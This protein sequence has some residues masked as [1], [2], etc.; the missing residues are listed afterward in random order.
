M[1]IVDLASQDDGAAV[2]LGQITARTG[3]MRD[4]DRAARQA[5]AVG[6]YRRLTA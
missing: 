4:L 5:V 6:S 1:A 2:T 3:V